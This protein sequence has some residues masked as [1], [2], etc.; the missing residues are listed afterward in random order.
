MMFQKVILVFPSL[1]QLW[2]FVKETTINYSE[3]NSAELSLT[4]NCRE[5]DVTMVKEKYYAHSQDVVPGKWV[6]GKAV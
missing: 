4:C 2:R 5:A 6:A 3:F 1:S